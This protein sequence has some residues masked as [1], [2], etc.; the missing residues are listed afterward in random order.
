MCIRD[1][2]QFRDNSSIGCQEIRENTVHWLKLKRA[3]DGEGVSL[4]H[5]FG[6][7]PLTFDYNIWW[8]ETRT[9]AVSYGSNVFGY[10]EPIT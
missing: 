4:T 8:Q 3:V 1:R 9:I 2:V 6:V 10:V 7:N 5:P